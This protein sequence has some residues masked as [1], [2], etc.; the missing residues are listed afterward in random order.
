MS[1]SATRLRWGKT[2]SRWWFS[3]V[4]GGSAQAGDKR[5]KLD[6]EAILPLAPGVGQGTRC[7]ICSSPLIL[8]EFR[9]TLQP[10]VT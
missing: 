1:S 2:R 10:V 4:L 6:G 5:R 7:A 3:W 8:L 9:R